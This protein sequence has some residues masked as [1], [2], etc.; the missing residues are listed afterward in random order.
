MTHATARL[1]RFLD[2]SKGYMMN[3]TNA[4]VE[5]LLEPVGKVEV[6][7]QLVVTGQFLYATFVEADAA[8]ITRM[9]P[10]RSL[11]DKADALQIKGATDN[12]VETAR[13]VDYP[14]GK[15]KG[16]DRGPKEQQAMNVRT[17]IK[18]AWGALKHAR[19]ELD[20]IG[21]DDKTGYQAMRV[22]AKRALDEAGKTW[23]GFTVP[24]A[25]DKA[26]KALAREQKAEKDILVDVMKQM[27]R[28]PN[29]SLLQYNTRV[30]TAAES[31]V[32]VAYENA[33]INFAKTMA[34]SILEK[35]GEARAE[36]VAYAL[37]GLLGIEYKAAEF[38]EADADAALKAYAE[39]ETKETVEET[40][41]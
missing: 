20:K 32:S 26:A 38:S 6:T 24:T 40:V 39:A 28:M 3:A 22:L 34:T 16:D 17:I 27:P 15:E 7:Q 36:A 8:E 4:V 9:D 23:Q 2:V 37:L 33:E 35:H 14:L 21:Y 31:A 29:E 13:K 5:G 30:A 18:Q 12:M 11:V 19:L 25:A 10:I 41:E 1:A